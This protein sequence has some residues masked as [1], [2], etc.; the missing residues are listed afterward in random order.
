MSTQRQLTALL[1]E[2]QHARS[3]LAQARVLARGWRTV[4][5]LSPTD[6]RLLARHAGFEGAEDILEGLSQR[7]GGLAPA[8]LLRVL[9]N[10]RG[11]DGSN[12]S[13]LLAAFRDPRRRDEAISLGAN[14]ASDLLA[15]PEADDGPEAI[16][17]AIEELQAVE[18]SIVESPEEALAALNALEPDPDAEDE[19][20]PASESVPEIDDTQEPEPEPE[21]VPEPLPPP[22][23]P[24]VDWSRWHSAT[25]SRRP[26]PV[27]REAIRPSVA[28]A[29]SRRFEARAVMGALG[30]EQ[31]VFSQLRVL[32]RELS[33]FAGSSIGTLQELIEAFPDGWARRRALCALLE[34]GIPAETRDVLELVACLEREL[35]RR[36]CLGILARQGDLRGT[37]LS[38]A[39]DLV[40]SDFAKRRLVS[41]AGKSSGGG[42]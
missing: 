26:A 3:P 15:E 19:Q 38:R 37:L 13:E 29:G 35:D 24:V 33:G 31:S 9:A 8:M 7:T 14:L 1:H 28:D 20:K 36:W 22:P 4:R 12:V 27:P 21:P 10:A 42:N 39:L 40:E 16:G 32:R 2:L 41:I 5:Q 34:A 17:E 25:E 18:E 6:R 30:A 23:P 11:A